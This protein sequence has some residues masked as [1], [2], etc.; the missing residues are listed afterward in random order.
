[1]AHQLLY[2]LENSKFSDGFWTVVV[3]KLTKQGHEYSNDFFFFFIDLPP[4]LD[5]VDFA[6]AHNG[7]TQ[8]T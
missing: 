2:F 7:L 4:P 6:A 3:I 8:L 5:A 1:M